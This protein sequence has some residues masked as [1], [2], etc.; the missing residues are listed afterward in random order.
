MVGIKQGEG[1]DARESGIAYN[2]QGYVSSILNALQQSDGYD[3]DLAGRITN[4]ILANGL[5]TGYTYDY[6]GNITSI[7]PPGK[8]MHD[9]DY[10]PVDLVSRYAPPAVEPGDNATHYS[11]NLNK[12]LTGIA[13]PDGLS[14]QLSYNS[15]GRISGV[16]L[17]GGNTIDYFYHDTTN[18]LIGISNGD[19]DLTWEYDGSLPTAIGLTGAVNADLAL[20]YNNDYRVSS[21]SV[22]N[23]DAINYSYNADGAVSQAGAMT[24][25]RYPDGRLSATSLGNIDDSYIYNGFGDR[26]SYAARYMGGKIFTIEHTAI[27]KLGRITGKTETFDGLTRTWQY[28]YDAVGQL[29][30][31]HLDG[32]LSS[33]YEYD[34]VGNRTG[35]TGGMGAITAIYD[36]QDRLQTY[37]ANTYTYNANGELESKTNGSGTTLYEYDVLGNLKTVTLPDG[38]I[39]EYIVDGMN[40]R[41]GKKVNDALV[42]GF[43]YKDQLSPVAQLDGSE[44]VVSTFVYG[45]KINVPDYMV[46]GGVTYRI[47]TDHLGS[48]RIVI[49]IETGQIVQRMEFDEFGNVSLNTNP[50]FQPFG[51]AGGLYDAQTGLVRFG[52]RDYDAETGR[53]TAKDPIGFGGEDVNLYRY[54][55]NDPVNINDP[56]GKQIADACQVVDNKKELD[57]I[58]KM[59]KEAFE[60]GDLNEF[61]RLD[62]KERELFAKTAG[63]VVDAGVKV[64]E[65]VGVGGIGTGGLIGTAIRTVKNLLKDVKNTVFPPAQPKQP[66]KKE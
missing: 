4:V 23:G 22:N 57:E 43:V 51:F 66:E 49:D 63:H 2:P 32:V 55:G 48:P 24:I 56:N 50:G 8:P 13:R 19:A 29:T 64:A 27:D 53:W 12:Q 44:N 30:D 31:V 41:I 21:L 58:R 17:P 14:L 62:Q 16:Q 25:N 15:L 6:N 61:A 38:A 65:D 26:S 7:T 5:H 47:I 54:C 9:F 60:K 20:T 33:H 45:T 40:R 59:K 11:Y 18:N 1:G 10:T 3:Y 52:A 46:R 39:I 37:G 35:Y 36:D 42:S 34:G 28:T